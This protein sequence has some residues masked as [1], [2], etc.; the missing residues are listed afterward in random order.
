[1]DK[2]CCQAMANK[3]QG[4]LKAALNKNRISAFMP[5]PAARH[6]WLVPAEDQV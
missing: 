1:M 4:G 2:F 5:S 6:L 3:T